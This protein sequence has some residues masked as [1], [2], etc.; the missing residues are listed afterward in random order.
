RAGRARAGWAQLYHP[1]LGTITMGDEVLRQDFLQALVTGA[2]TLRYQ[3]IVALTTGRV[4]GIE[5][6]T[7]WHRD[8]QEISPDAFL[9][10]LGVRERQALGR[11]VLRTGL[12]QLAQWLEAG[13][14]VFLSINVTPEELDTQE[15]ADSVFDILAGEPTVSPH[16]LVLEVLEIGEILERKITLEHLHRLR[17][18]GMK[19]ALDDVGSAYASLLRLKN[20]PIDAIKIDQGFIR[21]LLYKPQ[22]LVFVESLANIGLGM[23]VTITVEGVETEAHIALLREMEVHYLQ[24][25]AISKP[26]EAE[27]VPDFVRDFVLGSGDQD[28]PLLALYRHLGWVHVAEEAALNP[29]IF[30]GA[31]SI[32]CPITSWLH[33]H[34]PELPKVEELVA[35]HEKVHALGR[36]ILRVRQGGNRDELHR[37]LGELHV[38]SHVFQEGLGQA[39]KAM[40]EKTAA[41][42]SFPRSK[43][44]S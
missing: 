34:A 40:R 1:D 24:G 35:E 2:V 19:I 36:E 27:R 3:P 44:S 21:D 14:E 9:S 37:L 39:V 15:F 38:H 22:D 29:E 31:D 20:L 13:L 26:L 5:A 18:A 30:D 7:R 8:G 43:E 23:D 32:S 25:Y 11:F 10:S 17:G 4:A 33:A 12:Q 16:N 42:G 6:L 41:T 28:T